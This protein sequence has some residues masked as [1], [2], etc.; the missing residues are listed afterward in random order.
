MKKLQFFNA[1]YMH[2]HFTWMF[3]ERKCHEMAQSHIH[4][5]SVNAVQ[6]PQK[7]LE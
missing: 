1:L 2:T 4:A 3:V 7:G 5:V 6:S